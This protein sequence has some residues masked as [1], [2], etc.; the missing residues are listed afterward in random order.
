[1]EK[2]PKCQAALRNLA[3][4]AK[5][6]N[7]VH[8][9]AMERLYDCT[10]TVRRLEAERQEA[11]SFWTYVGVFGAGVATGVATVIVLLLSI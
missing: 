7:G 8:E 2:L 6:A 3:D 5:V 10:V 11:P 1:M 9:Q 4:D